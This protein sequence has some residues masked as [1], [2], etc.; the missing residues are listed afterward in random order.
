MSVADEHPSPAPDRDGRGERD[1]QDGLPD[2]ALALARHSLEC[3][4]RAVVAAGNLLRVELKLA[5]ASA[6]A[7]VW[8]GFLLAVLAFGAWLGINALIV[9]AVFASSGSVLLGTAV[10]LF[11]N[12]A[13]AVAVLF[14]M[15]RC[16]R[17]IGLPRT[18]RLL[19]QFPKRD[20]ITGSESAREA[21]S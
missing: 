11:A 21:G 1:A 3:A 18:R 17:D 12:V 9:A 6:I 14:F 19:R 20:T 5:G 10:V 4:I 16:W 7:L 8:L 2:D 15:K 13:G